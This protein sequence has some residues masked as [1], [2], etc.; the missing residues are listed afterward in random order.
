[1]NC[2]EIKP[3]LSAYLDKELELSQALEVASHLQKCPPC[4]AYLEKLKVLSEKVQTHITVYELPENLK[5]KIQQKLRAEESRPTRKIFSFGFAAGIA[6]CLVAVFTTKTLL[7][8]NSNTGALSAVTMHLHSMQEG[9]LVDV[10]SS[11]HHVVKPWLA[12]KLNFTFNPE[13]YDAEGFK[14][15]G[16]RLEYFEGE[17]AVALVYKRRDHIINLLVQRNIF[18]NEFPEL[19]TSNGFHI[20]AWKKQDLRYIAVSDI[21][22]ADLEKLESLVLTHRE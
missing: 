16:A 11:D 22:N 5:L 21:A 13:D 9:H 17:P 6:A 18:K 7:Y 3:L 8:P 15:L 20:R 1:M 14:L 12:G 2:S 10:A 19:S 4:E